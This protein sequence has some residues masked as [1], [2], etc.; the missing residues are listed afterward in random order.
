MHVGALRVKLIAAGDPLIQDAVITGHD[1]DEIGALVFLNP[2]AV[3][4]LS[5]EAVR[6]KLSEALK[7]FSATRP[8]ARPIPSGCSS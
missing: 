4:D 2:G 8:E 6:E 1:R 5:T 3:K 7:A